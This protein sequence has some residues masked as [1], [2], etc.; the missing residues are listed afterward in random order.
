[1][2]NTAR[3]NGDDLLPIEREI[4][5]VGEKYG[6]EPNPQFTEQARKQAILEAS[7]EEPQPEPTAEER[8]A[9]TGE[10]LPR[11]IDSGKD[12]SGSGWFSFRNGKPEEL[13][14]S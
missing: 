13:P 2:H 9:T 4:L 6:I 3:A 11:A 10:Q 14:F 7:V 12:G 5:R 1:M 8:A